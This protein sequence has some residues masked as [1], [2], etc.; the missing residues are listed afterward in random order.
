MDILLNEYHPSDPSTS[1]RAVVLGLHKNGNADLK[2]HM[3][4]T[5]VA[6]GV[7]LSTVKVTDENYLDFF[8]QYNPGLGQFFQHFRILPEYRM[9]AA[10]KEWQWHSKESMDIIS[11]QLRMHNIYIQHS[12]WL[13][14]CQEITDREFPATSQQPPIWRLYELKADGIECCIL[15]ILRFDIFDI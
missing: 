3:A 9:I 5:N 13:S 15:E 6:F 2:H 11:D 7:A 4:A 10:G 1:H 12:E 8:R 14:R